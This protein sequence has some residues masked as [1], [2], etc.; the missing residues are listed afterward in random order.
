MTLKDERTWAMLAMV[1]SCFLLIGFFFIWFVA[2][3]L[4]LIGFVLPIVGAIKA[5][6]GV[7]Y[8]YPLTIRFIN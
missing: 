7:C 8:H 4:A 5:N 3:I 6:D 2:P 1:A